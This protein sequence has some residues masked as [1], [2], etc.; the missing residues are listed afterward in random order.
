MRS[1]G[2]KPAC[3]I[4][5]SRTSTGGTTGVKPSPTSFVVT[6]CTSASSSSTASRMR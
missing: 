3:S 4:A 2:K 1:V 6:H 5:S